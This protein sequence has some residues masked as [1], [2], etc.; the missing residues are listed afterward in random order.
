MFDKV[1]NA[2]L[3]YERR[4]N[5]LK[6]ICILNEKKQTKNSVSNTLGR[7]WDVWKDKY[8]IKD[9]KTLI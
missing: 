2:P 6:Y 5:L 3:K 1:L 8:S 7:K 4:F 9:I